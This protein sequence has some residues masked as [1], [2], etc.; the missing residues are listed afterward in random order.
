MA[1]RGRALDVVAVQ[2]EVRPRGGREARLRLLWQARSSRVA[3]APSVRA[4]SRIAGRRVSLLAQ[5]RSGARA[6]ALRLDDPA[7]PGA[8]PC[9]A[10]GLRRN[11]PRGRR[12]ARRS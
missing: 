5:H 12:H 7:H 10:V 8:S 6:L 11:P 1:G 9:R 3:V 4:A 2:R